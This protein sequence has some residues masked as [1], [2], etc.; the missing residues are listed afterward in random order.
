MGE[1][2]NGNFSNRVVRGLVFLNL[3]LAEHCDAETLPI[4]DEIVD[5]VSATISQLPWFFLLPVQVMI[6]IIGVLVPIIKSKHLVTQPVEKRLHILNR[7]RRVPFFGMLNKLILTS[8]YL[9]LF[10]VRPIYYP[11]IVKRDIYERTSGR[12]KSWSSDEHQR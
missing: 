6:S 12:S 7:L 11:E 3:N 1:L 4:N 10:D 5:Y 8:A 2:I 9:K